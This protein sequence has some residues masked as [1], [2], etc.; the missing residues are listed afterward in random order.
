MGLGLLKIARGLSHIMTPCVPVDLIPNCLR[1]PINQHRDI[2]VNWICI[3]VI[4]AKIWPSYFWVF[5]FD[6]I[7]VMKL[8]SKC[9]SSR[10][11]IDRSISLAQSVMAML[12]VLSPPKWNR[13]RARGS[14]MG[15]HTVFGGIM[16]LMWCMQLYMKNASRSSYYQ[17]TLRIP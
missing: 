16:V 17:Y 2:D 3:Y 7:T 6:F 15:N 1:S 8:S 14:K 5:V 10:Q 12:T 13:S 4:R 9:D 11:W